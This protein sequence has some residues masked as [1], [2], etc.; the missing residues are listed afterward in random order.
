MTSPF[1]Y[2]V[3]TPASVKPGVNYPVVFAL[4]GV[5]YTEKDMMSTIAE[6]NE[7]LIV[8][9]VRGH[10]P[11]EQ[12]YA[13]YYLKSFGNPERE[14]FDKGVGMLEQFIDYAV[15]QYP[16][17]P[18]RMY[19]IGFSQGAI[20]S[21]TLALKLGPKIK[22]IIA[23]NGYIPS[24]VKEEYAIQATDH[25]SVFLS[26]GRDD[27]IFPPHIGEQ[28]YQYLKDRVNRI[29][30]KTYPA[31]HEISEENRQDVTAWLRKELLR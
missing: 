3:Q 5:G 1:A 10:L 30:Y 12:G 7:G 27:P 21:M 18:A 24:F 14:L 16:I 20:L 13:Y 23:M 26:D 9:G 15:R 25:L 29:A 31:A 8:I 4:H 22:G 19:L 28:N 6:L 17:D 11:Y 2:T